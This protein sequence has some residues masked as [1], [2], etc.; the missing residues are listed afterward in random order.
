MIDYGTQGDTFEIK[1]RS[2]LSLLNERFQSVDKKELKEK[3]DS[4]IKEGLMVKNN[5]IGKCLKDSSRE[6]TP[7]VELNQ[8]IVL[9]YFDTV[10]AK[11]GVHNIL[12]KVGQP[13][14]QYVFFLNAD[15]ELEMKM[16]EEYA[17]ADPNNRIIF[18]VV[19]GNIGKLLDKNMKAYKATDEIL[20]IFD[21]QCTPS[22]AAQNGNKFSTQEYFLKYEG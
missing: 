5:N 17:K 20:K 14:T 4:S 7:T 1:D 13:L 18:L 16:A 22:I 11:K 12:D 10:V 15:S 19:S 9:P 2:L 8:D 6:H 3:V 21:I